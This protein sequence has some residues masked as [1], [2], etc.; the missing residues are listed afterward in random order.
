MTLQLAQEVQNQW[1]LCRRCS[2][3][4]NKNTKQLLANEKS[5]HFVT[6]MTATATSEFRIDGLNDS[7]TNVTRDNFDTISVSV[8]DIIVLQI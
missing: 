6:Q 3:V 8:S 1:R 5:D 2:N 7:L 4:G